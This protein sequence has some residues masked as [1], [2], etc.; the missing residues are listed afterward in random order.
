M[1]TCWLLEISLSGNVYTIEIHKLG[2]TFFSG[3]IY[4]YTTHYTWYLMTQLTAHI[5]DY[6][7]V[8][9][10]VEHIYIYIYVTYTYKYIYMHIHTHICNDN[11]MCKLDYLTDER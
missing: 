8:C 7:Y 9:V 4:Q 5:S 3:F 1:I 11:F 6:I 2:L 10:Y